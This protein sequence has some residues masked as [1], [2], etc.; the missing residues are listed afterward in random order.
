M[1]RM[2]PVCQR[3]FLD[4]T[5]RRGP[6][7]QGPG[8]RGHEAIRQQVAVRAAEMGPSPGRR[9]SHEGGRGRRVERQDPSHPSVPP[10]RVAASVPAAAA[11]VDAEWETLPPYPVHPRARRHPLTVL[12]HHLEE[13]DDDL[14]GGADEHLARGRGKGREGQGVQQ[15]G[16]GVE[17][18]SHGRGRVPQRP[19][20]TAR[21]RW[22]S[23]KPELG[24]GEPE[25]H[26]PPVA[27]GEPPGVHEKTLAQRD[28]LRE[29][30]A[31]ASPGGSRLGE[32]PPRTSPP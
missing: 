30:Q 26:Q 6:G 15:K 1:R 17:G 3:R 9:R 24:R 18:V 27:W 4:G 13:L 32:P 19:P 16:E 11:A 25:E 20:A 14:R 10:L 22:V 8:T 7:T 29:S 28:A 2:A 12:H 5:G 21:M 23:R 31:R